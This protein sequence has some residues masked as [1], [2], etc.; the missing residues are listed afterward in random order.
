M[1]ILHISAECFPI[2]KVGGLADVVGALPKYQKDLGATSS[3]VMPYY[4]N[5]FTQN[6]TF[7]T[8]HDHYI[9]LGHEYYHF[10]V[11]KLTNHQLGFD[12]FCIDIPDLLY[13]E[14]VYSN[15]DTKRFLAFQI[16][17]LDWILTL[18]ATPDIIHV[19]TI[20]MQG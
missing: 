2:A 6:N 7:E 20:I 1:K 12:L 5:T 3:V 11:L 17:T 10:K 13:T 9:S 16:A 4:N 14:F 19:H 18:K 15:A 8:L